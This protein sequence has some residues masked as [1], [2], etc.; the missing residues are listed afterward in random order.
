VD[1]LKKNL[2]F[3]LKPAMNVNKKINILVN[4]KEVEILKKK[5]NKDE[6]Y[7][8]KD[9]EFSQLQNDVFELLKERE[10]KN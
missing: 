3:L 6:K 5:Y 4:D 10:K 8:F 7:I 1:H 9:E 2:Y